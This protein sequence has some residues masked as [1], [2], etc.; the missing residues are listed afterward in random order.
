MMGTNVVVTMAQ[1]LLAS[2]S[3][4]EKHVGLCRVVS[5][6]RVATDGFRWIHLSKYVWRDP[7]GQ[8]RP[9]EVVERS[10]RKGEIDAVCIIPILKA[11]G[12]DPR[13]VLISQFRPPTDSYCMEFPAGLVDDN[14]TPAEAALRELKEECGYVGEIMDVSPIVYVDSGMS[15]ACM[16]YVT[17][18]VD[19]DLPA[20]QNPVSALEDSEFI[21]VENIP[22]EFLLSV[23]NTKAEQGWAIDARLY[24]YAMVEEQKQEYI[25]RGQ[26]WHRG[27]IAGGVLLGLVLGYGYHRYSK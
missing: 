27:F 3:N 23:L 10:T 18:S 4:M 15:S 11:R 7:S 26:H 12:H 5:K 25:R 2:S 14:E 17:V 19:L 20:N 8:E 6:E 24:T 16:R 21:E 1:F 22:C 9:W 13:V